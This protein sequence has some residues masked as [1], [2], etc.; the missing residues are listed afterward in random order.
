MQYKLA[1]SQ[2]ASSHNTKTHARTHTLGLRASM[3]RKKK[4]SRS[5]MRQK[6]MGSQ[7]VLTHR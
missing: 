5:E 2:P 1:A 4:M 3:L 6:L 7:P